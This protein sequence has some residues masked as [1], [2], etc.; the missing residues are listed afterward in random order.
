MSAKCKY[1]R[2]NFNE[3]KDLQG[4]CCLE[5]LPPFARFP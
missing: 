2:P 4:M 5:I 1:C 3:E